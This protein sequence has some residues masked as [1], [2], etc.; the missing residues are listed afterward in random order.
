M[1]SG[2]GLVSVV[3]SLALAGSELRPSSRAPAVRDERV[4]FESDRSFERKI[5]D[6]FDQASV[7]FSGE[8]RE[9]TLEGATVAVIT[10]WKGKLAAE[11]VMGTGTTD[12]RDGTFTHDSEAFRFIKGEKY[13]LFAYG[14][15]ADGAPLEPLRTSVCQ[16]NVKVSQAGATIAV[17]DKIRGRFN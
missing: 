10:A 12:N 14:K 15:T 17:L 13:V 7:V 1:A 6:H 16:P 8:V 11:V 9:L 2:I 4:C 3:A 5:R